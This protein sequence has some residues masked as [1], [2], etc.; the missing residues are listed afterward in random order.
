MMEG[1]IFQAIGKP[2]KLTAKNHEEWLSLRQGIGSSEVA[3]ILGVNKWES[4]YQLWLRK[5]KRTPPKEENFAMKAGHYLEDA[6]ARFWQDET[7]KTVIK[8]SAEE[9]VFVHPEL[10]Y[11]RVSPDREFWLTDKKNND[12]GVLECKTTQ[13]QIDP[14]NIPQ[15]W[16]CQVQ[17]QLGVM[18]RECGSIAWL[19]SGREFGYRDIAFV[20]EFYAWMI[21]EVTKFW[22]NHIIADVEPEVSTVEDVLQKYAKHSDGKFI[23]AG[24]ETLKA[25]SELKEVKE[26]IALL[27]EK[28]D[29]LESQI[30][31][32]M[33]DSEALTY[34][35]ST[36]A[37]WKAPKDSQRFDSKLFQIEQPALYAQYLKISSGSRRF[38]LK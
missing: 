13:F 27:E 31:I 32:M 4:P 35:G 34:K 7:G 6:V 2:K 28:K 24:D 11:L 19:S 8:R 12:R 3:S 18:Q 15:Y 23:E 38:L 14:E 26:Q 20:P 9:T 17:Y 33:Q 30:K 1:N 37:T 21:E 36:L 5:T 25:Y 22:N 16:F 29:N 10:D